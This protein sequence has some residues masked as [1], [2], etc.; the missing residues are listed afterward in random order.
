MHASRKGQLINLSCHSSGIT[1]LVLL[2]RSAVES[3]RTSFIF[4]ENSF[5]FCSFEQNDILFL[6]FFVKFRLSIFCF[7]FL[8]LPFIITE[9]EENETKRN[10]FFHNA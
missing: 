2:L 5:R 1:V 10:D 9:G 8:M 4:K 6:L 3:S 7:C